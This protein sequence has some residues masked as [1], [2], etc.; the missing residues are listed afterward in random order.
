[1]TRSQNMKHMWKY[2]HIFIPNLIALIEG[3]ERFL[4]DLSFSLDSYIVLAYDINTMD[5]LHTL[6]I[7]CII[8]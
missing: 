1:M 8:V 7:P 3:T 2:S 4:Y 5:W 6:K